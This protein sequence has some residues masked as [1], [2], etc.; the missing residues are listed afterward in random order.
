MI[1]QKDHENA[2]FLTMGRGLIGRK[3]CDFYRISRP[4]RMIQAG[5]IPKPAGTGR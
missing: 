2:F 1:N 4:L 5:K 3:D